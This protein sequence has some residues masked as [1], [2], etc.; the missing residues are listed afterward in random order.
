[1]SMPR[2]IEINADKVRELMREQK[3]SQAQLGRLAGMSPGHVATVLLKGRASM[4][5]IRAMARALGVNV[6][7]ILK[8]AER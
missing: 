6:E 3:L 4:P 1:M 8:E 5:T 2:G 7:E